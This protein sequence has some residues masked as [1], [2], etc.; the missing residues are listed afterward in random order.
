LLQNLRFADDIL[1][2]GKSLREVQTMLEDVATQTAQVGL[3]LHAGKTKILSNGI[4][5]DT[6]KTTINICNQ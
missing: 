3:Q 5:K 6:R 4:G 1:L 2:I